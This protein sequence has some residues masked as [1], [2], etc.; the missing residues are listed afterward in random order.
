MFTTFRVIK[1]S[2]PRFEYTVSFIQAHHPLNVCVHIERRRALITNLHS[3]RRKFR[4]RH[5]LPAILLDVWSNRYPLHLSQFLLLPLFSGSA[6]FSSFSI[7][8]TARIWQTPVKSRTLPTPSDASTPGTA[9]NRAAILRARQLVATR[10]IG[11]ETAKAISLEVQVAADAE[12]VWKSRAAEAEA[13]LIDLQ[14]ELTVLEDIKA[15]DEATFTAALTAAQERHN[16]LTE[17]HS[18]L[19][20]EHNLMKTSNEEEIASLKDL[21]NDATTSADTKLAT[22]DD[23]LSHNKDQLAAAHHDLEEALGDA[24]RMS[25]E[26]THLRSQLADT[27]T[28][29]AEHTMTI[30]ALTDEVSALTRE[31]NIARGVADE[32]KSA[33]ARLNDEVTSAK[34]ASAAAAVDVEVLTQQ[35][36]TALTRANDT[37]MLNASST[38]ST[39]ELEEA[40][41][42]LDTLRRQLQDSQSTNRSLSEQLAVLKAGSVI[43]APHATVLAKDESVIDDIT[44]LQRKVGAITNERD[45]ALAES[46]ATA[47]ELM[48]LK[49]DFRAMHEDLKAAQTDAAAAKTAAAAVAQ[50]DS[51]AGDAY[52]NELA[53]MQLQIDSLTKELV[54]SRE[55]ATSHREKALAAKTSVLEAKKLHLELIR[56]KND[57][58]KELKNFQRE[59]QPD[60]TTDLASAVGVTA[61]AKSATEE[62]AAAARSAKN[63]ETV[64]VVE[65]ATVL[66]AAEASKVEEEA[67]AARLA[68]L[69][70]EAQA[71]AAAVAAKEKVVLQP[72]VQRRPPKEQVDK[73]RAVSMFVGSTPFLPAASESATDENGKPHTAASRAAMWESKSSGDTSDIKKGGFSRGGTRGRSF[74]APSGPKC[75]LC[76]KTV[77]PMEEIKVE[78]VSY[79]KACFRCSVPECKKMVSAGNYASNS[80][81]IFCKPCFMKKFKE[82]GNYDEGFGGTQHKKKWLAQG[83]VDSEDC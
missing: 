80:G 48:V 29:T 46:Q 36:Q 5:G 53:S 57:A 79:C 72:A 81:K 58:L 66:A 35:L 43:P 78:G 41:E 38:V 74:M 19:E 34:A 51:R 12:E 23:L 40:T 55:V 61:E 37:A 76:S 11:P 4:S 71:T 54:A 52:T 1:I 64:K 21:L 65:T 73:P 50:A 62:E 44:V 49:T 17:A 32:A 3:C 25:K 24:L 16:T 42:L 18:V 82:K 60:S 31:L 27:G 70:A 67:E 33:E 56:E 10:R 75:P 15:R 20:A 7:S 45:A 77:Y 22:W 39:S 59:G 14:S 69:A 2:I 83:A 8:H 9:S 28:N 6:G 47:N 68:E 13:K 63:A 30:K 26:I